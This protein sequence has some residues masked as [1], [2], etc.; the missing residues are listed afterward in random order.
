MDPQDISQNGSQNIGQQQELLQQLKD[1]TQPA[2]PG[3]W[4]PA[5]GWWLLLFAV[6]LFA[7]VL[8]WLFRKHTARKSRNVWR[9]SALEEHRRLHKMLENG[10]DQTE[11]IA[12]LSVLMRRVA[13][14]VEPRSRIASLT[15][16]QWLS[17]LD[18]IGKTTEYTNGVGSVLYRHQYMRGQRL[19]DDAVNDLF[20]IT[21][22]TIKTASP[23]LHQHQHHQHQDH[24]HQEKGGSVA[25]L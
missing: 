14:A 13:L 2:N 3:W 15:D 9:I 7:G 21:A 25:A 22:N 8:Y 19:E 18:A 20:D 16:D 11:V 1:V 5:P 24:Q 23:E 10:S 6:L 17:K 12:K 4:P